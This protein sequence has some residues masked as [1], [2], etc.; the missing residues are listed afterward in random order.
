LHCA[1]QPTTIDTASKTAI[2]ETASREKVAQLQVGIKK[3]QKERWISLNS[4]DRSDSTLSS[5]YYLEKQRK[6]GTKI[7]T[8]ATYQISKV[9]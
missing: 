1:F 6:P 7:T 3:F 8:V 2:S 4:E 5:V 9:L